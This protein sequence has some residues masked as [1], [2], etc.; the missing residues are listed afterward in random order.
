MRFGV[1]DGF[2]SQGTAVS[3]AA[4]QPDN[5]SNNVA[6]VR[7]VAADALHTQLLIGGIS[8]SADDNAATVLIYG[9]VPAHS[10]VLDVTGV[11][12]LDGN[13]VLAL[14]QTS[15]LSPGWVLACTAAGIY[16]CA[17]APVQ[18]ARPSCCSAFDEASNSRL[19]LVTPCTCVAQRHLPDDSTYGVPLDTLWLSSTR[20]PGRL[21]YRTPG[22]VVQLNLQAQSC[23]SAGQCEAAPLCVCSRA[24]PLAVVTASAL[25]P[26]GRCR[27]PG[28]DPAPV[29]RHGAR[30]ASAAVCALHATAAISDDDAHPGL[31]PA[32]APGAATAGGTCTGSIRGTDGGSGAAASAAR[33]HSAV[34]HR[35]AAVRPWSQLLGCGRRIPHDPAG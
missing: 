27:A 34:H 5:A 31:V 1:S 12:V 7:V 4:V 16:K 11:T 3:L 15:A 33:G 26:G 9:S 6:S 18:L 14:S 25:L 20:G 29:V 35:R 2:A 19:L 10:Y 32:T 13:S 22:C 30:R 24:F 28:P 21:H 23:G 8:T 17:R